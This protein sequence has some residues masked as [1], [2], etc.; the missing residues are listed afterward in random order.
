LA[1]YVS[2][3]EEINKIIRRG[4]DVHYGAMVIALGMLTYGVANSGPTSVC[5]ILSPVL[6]LSAAFR[7]ILEQVK[8]LRRNAAYL[9]VFYEGDPNGI[10]WE[11]DLHALR[12]DRTRRRRRGDR[13][14]ITVS[15]ILKAFPNEYD[16]FVL[17]CLI[18]ALTRI[19]TIWQLNVAEA[20]AAAGVEAAA[21]GFWLAYVFRRR[22]RA[23]RSLVGG[24][25]VER[26]YAAEWKLIK[27][28]RAHGER[29]AV[30]KWE[31]AASPS[32]RTTWRTTWRTGLRTLIA[33][34]RQLVAALSRPRL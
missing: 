10:F 25:T 7:I 15:D 32:W 31:P 17:I 21:C 30:R 34:Y 12:R 23:C 9:R 1:E 16:W 29:R 19:Y 4:Y 26:R 3:R 28:Y 22:R 11:T 2:L 5:L 18:V 14:D 33:R 13:E 24:G 6:I 27:R 8:T 20:S